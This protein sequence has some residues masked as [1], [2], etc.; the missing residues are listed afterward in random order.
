[1]NDPTLRNTAT[2]NAPAEG[3][4]GTTS[5]EKKTLSSGRENGGI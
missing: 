4:E 2:V 1:M 3:E 5:E